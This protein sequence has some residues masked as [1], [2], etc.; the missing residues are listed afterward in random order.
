RV[1]CF[2]VADQ[3][4]N[5][6]VTGLA[7]AARSSP[8][9]ASADGAGLAI[10]A[11]TATMTGLTKKTGTD[12]ERGGPA[13]A[14]ASVLHSAV[15]RVAPRLS[16]FQVSRSAPPDFGGIVYQSPPGSSTTQDRPPS[17]STCSTVTPAAKLGTTVI[18][19]FVH[20]QFRFSRATCTGSSL[21]F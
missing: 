1:N 20:L 18:S 13:T 9:S 10:S 5:R 4:R 11:S 2:R 3:Q 8:R 14:F 19:T 21:V 15:I 7:S 12:K 6:T 16:P 17:A